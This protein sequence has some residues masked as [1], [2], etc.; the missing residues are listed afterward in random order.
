MEGHRT[1]PERE[2]P[3]S[4]TKL[5]C[6]PGQVT[7]PLLASGSP[8]LTRELNQTSKELN[9]WGRDRGSGVRLPEFEP[10]VCPWEGYLTSLCLEFLIC[11][12]GITEL[13]SQCG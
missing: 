12:I 11:E 1:G 10:A 9:Q 7:A 13:T 2:D 8:A 4:A 5:L 3:S 6:D